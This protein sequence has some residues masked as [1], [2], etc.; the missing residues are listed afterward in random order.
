MYFTK[1]VFIDKERFDRVPP[2]YGFDGA[3]RLVLLLKGVRGVVSMKSTPETEMLGN[4]EVCMFEL[5]LNNTDTD[6]IVDMEVENFLDKF[7]PEPVA[8]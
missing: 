8:A 7:A 4:V 5:K 1:I 3:T 2:A 6:I